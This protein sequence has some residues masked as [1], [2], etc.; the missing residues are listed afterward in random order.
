MALELSPGASDGVQ[1]RFRG[2]RA[3]DIRQ[4]ELEQFDRWFPWKDKHVREGQLK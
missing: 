2:D 4:D 1:G 3:F